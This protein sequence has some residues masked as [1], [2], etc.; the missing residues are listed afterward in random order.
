MTLKKT[1]KVLGNS[2]IGTD[3]II[4]NLKTLEEDVIA[5]EKRKLRLEYKNDEVKEQLEDVSEKLRKIENDFARAEEFLSKNNK[6]ATD[7]EKNT[8][9]TENLSSSEHREK[10]L[11]RKY[12]MEKQ[13]Y[14]KIYHQ[15]L[16]ELDHLRTKIHE[17]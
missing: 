12:Q 11:S 8:K 16:K 14:Q 3:T 15:K 5:F 13:N 2:I 17:I 9:I 10:I 4:T 6:N 1:N 7:L